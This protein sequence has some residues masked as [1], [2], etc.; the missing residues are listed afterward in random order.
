MDLDFS[1]EQT[2]LR[3]TA[4]RLCNDTLGSSVIRTLEQATSPDYAAPFWQALIDTGI[5]GLLIDEEQ[6]G[7]AMGALE[8]ALVYEE[9]GRAL[10]PSPH[11][12]S[13]ILSARLLQLAGSKAQRETLLPQIAR[14]DCIVVP[15]WQENGISADINACECEF[16]ASDD[17]WLIK[18]DKTLVPYAKDADYFLLLGKTG[19]KLS[20]LLLPNEGV[21]IN[22]QP[23]HADQSLYRIACDGLQ[24][25]GQS[26]LCG[27]VAKAWDSAMMLAQIALAA[28]AIGGASAMHAMAND[29][30]R[31]RRQFGQPIG[32]FQSLAHY[33]AD[34]ATEIEG[35]RYLVYQAAW[36]M[37][38]CADSCEASAQK[39]AL[40]AK[41]QA[42]AVFRRTT[43]SGVQ[44]HGGMGFSAEA[45]PQL[46]Y[47]RAK[48]QQ[49]MYWDS[50]YL[51]KRIAA[52][53]FKDGLTD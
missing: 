4:H 12:E 26:R 31:Q 34:A 29:Y 40:M 47:R 21:A 3:E 14:G 44:I 6:G 43:V 27:D 28:Q 35:A 20:A 9:F 41:L 8:C 15:A 38:Q 46:Y 22:A 50:N 1:E 25:A 37:D 18:G 48:H 39:L 53:V 2:L 45:D 42:C 32:A 10:A 13:S 5:T 7:V 49:L 16:Q 23:N 19:N 30:A 33:L 51:K 52:E 11:L 36:A 17:H 24:V